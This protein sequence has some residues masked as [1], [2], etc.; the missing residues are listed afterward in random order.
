MVSFNSEAG[1][2]CCHRLSVWKTLTM[3]LI[4]RF[5]SI[6]RWKFWI[7]TLFQSICLAHGLPLRRKFSLVCRK[8]ITWLKIMISFNIFRESLQS[9]NSSLTETF[10]FIFLFFSTGS[11]QIK[12]ITLSLSWS[13]WQ[14]HSQNLFRKTSEKL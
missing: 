5:Y 6:N 11:L 3:V 7:Q 4:K 12:R 10:F 8:T 14:L 9:F 13:K 2:I 1:I